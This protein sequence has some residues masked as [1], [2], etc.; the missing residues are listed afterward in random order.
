MSAG[1]T[2]VLGKLHLSSLLDGDWRRDKQGLGGLARLSPLVYFGSDRLDD[3]TVDGYY[4]CADLAH[5]RV[6]VREIRP[7]GTNVIAK[8]GTLDPTAS[9]T[10]AGYP[11]ELACPNMFDLDTRNLYFGQLNSDPSNQGGIPP[12]LELG[13]FRGP[14]VKGLPMRLQQVHFRAFNPRGESDEYA[15]YFLCSR[16]VGPFGANASLEL[17]EDDS[18]EEPRVPDTVVTDDFHLQFEIENSEPKV[19]DTNYWTYNSYTTDGEK[20]SA[21]AD[22]N[23][24]LV[25]GDPLGV[26]AHPMGWGVDSEGTET[27][28]FPKVIDGQE[29][30]GILEHFCP[31]TNNNV[32]SILFDT[33]GLIVGKRKK[34]ATK[35]GWKYLAP[36]E[37]VVSSRH[38]IKPG[39]SGG[40]GLYQCVAQP[41]WALLEKEDPQIVDN[42][43]IEW[44]DFCDDFNSVRVLKRPT[45]LEHVAPPAPGQPPSTGDDRGIG[46]PGYPSASAVGSLDGA[47]WEA[48]PLLQLQDFCNAPK[49]CASDGLI[50]PVLHNCASNPETP[51]TP[52]S[53]TLGKICLKDI[54]QYVIDYLFTRIGKDQDGN[55]LEPEAERGLVTRVYSTECGIRYDYITVAHGG[56]GN[57]PTCAED[58]GGGDLT[59]G[60][61]IEKTEHLNQLVIGFTN[62]EDNCTENSPPARTDV[63]RFYP[64]DI[65]P[66]VGDTFTKKGPCRP[67][68]RGS[69]DDPE[70]RPACAGKEEGEAPSG[71]EETCSKTEQEWE[72]ETVAPLNPPGPDDQICSDARK[73]QCP[74][75]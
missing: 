4:N 24:R 50:F 51:L 20:D 23:G 17:E 12:P 6:A 33:G 31:K 74:E 1:E 52:C 46:S 28:I 2:L 72:C 5:F 16:P 66:P 62:C 32:Y 44:F 18:T 70:T 27:P 67:C 25:I 64:C 22:Y 14:G 8:D 36:F 69:G 41:G 39:I 73:D 47:N 13:T 61:A 48:V 60:T 11:W 54:A 63:A 56:D 19:P 26:T 34:T 10:V 29:V 3:L 59:A 9:G 7:K 53:T 43:V 45:P 42:V 55:D 35:E 38:R 65:P 57:T 15:A 75:G 68:G 71:C 49:T 37:V 21:Q 58:D 30:D 40:E